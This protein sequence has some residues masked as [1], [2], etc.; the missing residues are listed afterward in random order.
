MLLKWILKRCKCKSTCIFNDE[1]DHRHL[2][3][4][5]T[6]YKLKNKDIEAILY[7]LQK[8]EL[9]IKCNPI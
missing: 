8:R 2:E 4:R 5:L 6:D 9:K 3:R 7:I 1:F